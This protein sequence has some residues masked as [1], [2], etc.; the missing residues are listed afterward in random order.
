MVSQR[1]YRASRHRALGPF[2]IHTDLKKEEANRCLPSEA[3]R[4]AAMR[5]RP[6]RP[7]GEGGSRSE[8]SGPISGPIVSKVGPKSAKGSFPA[9]P[10]TY[11]HFY[12]TDSL[13]GAG[14]K[15]TRGVLCRDID[16][17]LALPYEIFLESAR[18][19]A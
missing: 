17:V 13:A 1:F 19:F 9:Q 5:V 12:K 3:E 15:N 11:S 18:N 14:T 8:M 16:T 10:I 2:S 7:T 4:A 6:Q